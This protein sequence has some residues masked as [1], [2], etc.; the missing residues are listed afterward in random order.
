MPNTPRVSQRF[1]GGGADAVT[2]A[3]IF[4]T[5]G[6]TNYPM[7]GFRADP[8]SRSTRLQS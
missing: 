2:G 6:T 5:P 1:E 4:L 3:L 8:T 7:Y